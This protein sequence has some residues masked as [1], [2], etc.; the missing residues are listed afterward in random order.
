MTITYP[1]AD[2]DSSVGSSAPAAG[3]SHLTAIA[4]AIGIVFVVVAVGLWFGFSESQKAIESIPA[5]VIPLKSTP[6]VEQARIYEAIDGLNQCHK[7]TPDV[8]SADARTKRQNCYYAVMTIFTTPAIC[9]IISLDAASREVCKQAE[10]RFIKDYP[11]GMP[12]DTMPTFGAN[13]NSNT[14]KPGSGSGTGS[15]NKNSSSA[16]G[17]ASNTNTNATAPINSNTAGNTNT[18]GNTNSSGNTNA[19]GNQNSNGNTNQ[20]ATSSSGEVICVNDPST[21]ILLEHTNNCQ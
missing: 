15:S 10:A 5:A 6:E 4:I 19:S 1:K 20:T 7:N 21:I 18:S 14:Q 12:K 16:G 17:S 3:T 9:D 8:A 11:N 2:S 13:T